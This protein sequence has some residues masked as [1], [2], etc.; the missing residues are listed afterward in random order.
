M[1]DGQDLDG[2]VRLPVNDDEWKARQFDLPRAA[3]SKRPALRRGEN[4]FD[5][6]VDF[7]DEP[8]RSP[9]TAIA[10]PMRGALCLLNCFWVKDDLPCGHSIAEESLRRACSRVTGLT[11]PESSSAMRRAISWSHAAATDSSSAPSRLSINEPANS[12]RS[13][14]DRASALFRSLVASSVINAIVPR[15]GK[16]T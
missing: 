15:K 10:V 2:I 16:D 11:L 4:P 7:F 6:L 3:R 12:A 5:H 13:G 1:R 14:T 9:R 8:G